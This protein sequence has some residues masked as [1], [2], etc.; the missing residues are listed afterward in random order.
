MN[1][2]DRP[3]RRLEV[4]PRYESKPKRGSILSLGA[5]LNPA[6]SRGVFQTLIRPRDRSR[7]DRYTRERDGRYPRDS[8]DYKKVETSPRARRKVVFFFSS[9]LRLREL[10]RAGAPH[11]VSVGTA[12]RAVSALLQ[13]PAGQAEGDVQWQYRYS[14]FSFFTHISVVSSLRFGRSRVF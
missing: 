11:R 6:H 3:N 5:A 8:R 7:V 13:P 12:E 14:R 10:R 2:L 1:S 9:L 4:R